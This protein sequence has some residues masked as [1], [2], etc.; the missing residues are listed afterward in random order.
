[1]EEF[2]KLVS[3][4]ELLRGDEGCPWDKK[5]TIGA[6][7]T[8]LLEEVYEVIEAIERTDYVALKEELG[9]LLFHI[10]FISQIC[11]EEQR[12]GIGDVID[13]S[14]HKMYR[15]HPHVFLKNGDDKPIEH[16]WEQ[17]KREEK[18]DYS[19]VSAVPRMLP[20]LLRAYVV[21]KRAAR[22]GFDWEKLSDIYDKMYEEIQELREAEESGSPE[23][24]EE[25][26]GDLLFTIANISRFHGI[27]PE[28]ALR[29]TTDKFT[30][31]FAYVQDHADSATPDLKAMD[32]L[33]N[34]V[35]ENEKRG[36]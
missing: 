18:Q 17:I 13:D 1:M 36:K 23:R 28:N 8:F 32:A 34:E 12:F 7:K 14:Y 11:K 2:S 27:D 31:R 21:S 10:V 35:K 15:R 19:P 22:T 20:A 29:C 6:F 30:R 24:I 16:R 25:E 26:V 4:M 5:Q 3:L 33:W 9:D